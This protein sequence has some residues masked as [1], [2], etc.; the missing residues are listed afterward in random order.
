M[1]DAPSLGVC[2]RRLDLLMGER[3]DRRLQGLPAASDILAPALAPGCHFAHAIAAPPERE[4]LT[5][6][7]GWRY[8]SGS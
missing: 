6:R 1:L 5:H 7:V 8:S 3:L 2:Q 4:V